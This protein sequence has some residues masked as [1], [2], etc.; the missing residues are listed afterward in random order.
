MVGQLH[1]APESFTLP[2][3]DTAGSRNLGAVTSISNGGV[4]W[5]IREGVPTHQRTYT[6]GRTIATT[7]DLLASSAITG[8]AG[9]GWA[10]EGGQPKPF[11]PAGQQ[12]QRSLVQLIEPGLRGPLLELNVAEPAFD[13]KLVPHNFLLIGEVFFILPTG[14]RKNCP[15]NLSTAPSAPNCRPLPRSWGPPSEPGHQ[16]PK[17]GSGPD[18]AFRILLPTM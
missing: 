15:Q 11:S 5:D 3:K 13:R 9:R 4:G 7:R 10:G 2:H 6:Q 1:G 16:M 18:L 12:L 17:E 8:Q 14:R